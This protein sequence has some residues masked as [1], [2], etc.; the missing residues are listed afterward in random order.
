MEDV[1]YPEADD[2]LQYLDSFLLY[3]ERSLDSGG[4]YSTDYH[5]YGASLFV[6]FLDQRFERRLVRLIWEELGRRLSASMEGFD[7]VLR[8]EE[9]RSLDA[10][11]G[12]FAVWNYF[13]GSRYRPGYY[14]EGAKYPE[15]RPRDVDPAA[16]TAAQDSGEVDHLASAY[17][18]MLP[19]LRTGGVVVETALAHGWWSQHLARVSRDSA[20]VQPLTDVN[21]ATVAGWDQY[22]EV[23]LI[24]ACTEQ[25]GMGYGY[26]VS[27]EY[28]PALISEPPPVAFRLGPAY[29]NP[30]EPGNWPRVL[31]P[32]DLSA[33]SLATRLAVYTADGRL[34]RAY[35]L[36]ALPPRGYRR[37][38]WDGRDGQGQ[39]V[40]S[41]IYY[42]VLDA[43]GQRAAR[44]LGLIRR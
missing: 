20:Q 1:A 18:R 8:R 34:V 12:E 22:D 31:L 9:E 40:A 21:R 23:V 37:Y 39:P 5:V 36:G 7:R 6:H 33:P 32:F 44:P 30:F 16:G 2:Y 41:G 43:D 38:S 15:L 27:A 11:M 17:V 29:P 14:A 26:R 25:T 3:P 4:G 24:L 42:Y 19:R 13:T 28:D 10:A 35:E